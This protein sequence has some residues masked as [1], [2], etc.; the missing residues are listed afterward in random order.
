MWHQYMA[1]GRGWS[2]V[3]E[4]RHF[5]LSV[6]FIMISAA[7]RF[8]YMLINFYAILHN[9]PTS[10]E[11]WIVW[12]SWFAAEGKVAGCVAVATRESSSLKWHIKNEIILVK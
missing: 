4:F 10:R 6:P 11:K 2:L 12:G 7:G 8:F 3:T 1:M 5:F 9:L